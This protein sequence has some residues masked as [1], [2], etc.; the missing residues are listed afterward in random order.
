M[1]CHANR[2]RL[3]AAELWLAAAMVLSAS[4][5]SGQGLYYKEI[6]K[7]GRI[8]VFNIAANAERFEKGGELGPG[9]TRLGGGPNGETLVGDN[10]RALQLYYF[11]HGISEPVPEPPPPAPPAPPPYRFSGLMFGDYYYFEDDHLPAF[12]GQHGFWFR[13][14]YF[15]Y[16]HTWTPKLQTRF[17]L[18]SNSNGKLQGG[19][20]TPFVKDAYLRWTAFGRQQLTL[21]IQPSLTF[22][23]IENYWGL[24]HIEKT[25][26][27]L[28]RWDSSRDTGV[29]LGGP[30]NQK[31]T[32]KYAVQYGN[33][34]GNNGETDK[35]KGYRFAARYETNPGFNFEVMAGQFNRAQD[36]DRITLQG[37][38]GYRTKRWRVGA[39]YSYQ[40]R[41]APTGSVL[42]D[43]E[44][45]IA[46]AFA[47]YDLKIQKFSVF[48]RYDDY[49]DPCPDCSG[50]DYLPI[51]TNEPFSLLIAGLEFYVHPMVR[52]SPNVEL[53]SYDDP[54]GG[55]PTPKDDTVYR[56]TFYWNWP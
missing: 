40:E 27:D 7:D 24:R 52:F 38:G 47:V 48:A 54:P 13:R 5:V 33:E 25:P 42:D 46:S 45:D 41:E 37:F 19:A 21:G 36:A 31:Q 6:E 10:E 18:E 50:I 39:Q 44:L 22:D 3:A 9:I 1:R 43:V 26:L 17:R 16:D 34:S 55:R 35:F 2:F 4:S 12:E 29:T 11:K 15:T 32:L 28:Y 51:D 49:G 23:F 30:L 8:Y 53:V 56:L 14:L 20:I